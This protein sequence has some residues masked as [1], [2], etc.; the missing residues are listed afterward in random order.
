MLWHLSVGQVCRPYIVKRTM[1]GEKRVLQVRPGLLGVGDRD[2]LVLL[3]VL[4]VRHHDRNGA[5]DSGLLRRGVRNIQRELVVMPNPLFLISISPQI[6]SS[7]TRAGCSSSSGQLSS[8]A[9]WSSLGVSSSA[10]GE[11]RRAR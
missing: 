4:H 8:L 2:R 9:S 1:K 10:C 11:S 3:L 5:R 6:D 7:T